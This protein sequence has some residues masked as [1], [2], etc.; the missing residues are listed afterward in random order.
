MKPMT[1]V[2]FAALAVSMASCH[3]PTPQGV[4]S[5]YVAANGTDSSGGG[6]MQKPWAT[7]KYAA[8]RVPPG[9]TIHVAP[10]KYTGSFTTSAPGITYSASSADFS[11]AV[12]CAQ[13]AANHGDLST[14]ARLVGVG[15][16]TWSNSGNNVRIEGFDVTGPGLNGIYT[17]GN[18]TII[19]GNH[20]HDILTDTCNS[21]GGSGINLNGTNAE[22]AANYVHHIGPASP[23]GYVQGIYFLKDGGFAHNNITF[24]NSGFGIQLWHYPSHIE[25]ANNTVFNNLEGGIVLGTNDDHTVDY[26]TVSNNIVVNNKGDGINEQGSYESSTG[27]HNVYSHNL[28]YGNTGTAIVLQNDLKA[29]G[30][31]TSDPKFVNYTGSTSGDYH[32]QSTSPAMGAA[33]EDTAPAHDFDANARDVRFD[34]GGYQYMGATTTPPPCTCP[35]K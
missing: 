2:S 12:N 10:G 22:V 8:G 34:V 11:H 13:V 27:I 33:L 6:S 7:I 20:V 32:L 28:V 18:A 35:C 17:E 24:Q 30:T 14:C 9:S 4:T 5:F 21:N 31:V 23:C 19:R 16:T 1:I 26:V 25:L 3:R 15:E 29:T